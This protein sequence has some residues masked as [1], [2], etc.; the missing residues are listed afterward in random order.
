[1]PVQKDCAAAVGAAGMVEPVVT[2]ERNANQLDVVP[3]NAKLVKVP[4][5][6]LVVASVKEV[7][8][9]FVPALV[10]WLNL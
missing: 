7:T 6:A 3:V 8:A 4:L 10:P 1:V 9:V 2:V 5:F